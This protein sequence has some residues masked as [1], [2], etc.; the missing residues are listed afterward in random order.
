[1]TDQPQR[2]QSRWFDRLLLLAEL[3]GDHDQQQI[4]QAIGVT[5]G[6][7]TGW[8]QG[9]PPSPDSVLAA[10]EHYHVD[11]LEMLRVAYLPDD[12]DETDCSGKKI[13]KKPRQPL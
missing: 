9:V 5:K 2:K 7:V 6:T 3:H 13:R 12:D 1:M 11:P 10:A 4:A 8:K